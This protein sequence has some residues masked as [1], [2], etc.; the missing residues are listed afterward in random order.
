LDKPHIFITRKI[1]QAAIS[2]L[3]E[4]CIVEV[5][6][7]KFPPD[8]P[9]LLIK[10]GTSEGLISLLTDKIDRNL[11]TQSKGKLRVISQMAVGVDNIDLTAATE[12]K[13]PI[14]HTPGVLTESVA[15]FT[16]ALLLSIARRV[17][18]ADGEVHRGIWQPWGPDVLCG[19]DVYGAT[20]GIIGM[21]RIGQAV[22]KRARGFDM[23]VFYYD[24]SR[25]PGPEK[26]LNI[27]CVSMDDL[28]IRSDF[29]SI[30]ANL[31]KENHHLISKEQ[32]RKMK[33]TAYLINTSRGPLVDPL[34]LEWALQNQVIAGAA[35][36]V[37]ES[38]PMPA[39]SPLLKFKNLII[40][41]HIASASTQTRA[42]MA[43]ISA[44]NLLA[45]LK[46]EKLLF[47]A[48]PEVYSKN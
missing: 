8:Y 18:E 14:G 11:I 17:V 2:F 35:I 26:E 16:F 48:N 27:Q 9:F 22:A 38:E 6:D 44:R 29:V 34:A 25:L 33:S 10:A 1:D 4:S 23:K 28:L 15:D 31:T 46:G 32:F 12:N 5:W 42:N 20:L 19:A 24:C 30:H 47:C 36:D 37:A 21:G 13:L 3:A 7:K 45:G 43:M 41:P 40:T 39:N